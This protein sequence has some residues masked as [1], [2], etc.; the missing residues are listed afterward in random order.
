MKYLLSLAFFAFCTIGF[1]QN[2]DAIVGKWKT[3]DDETKEPKSIVELYKSSDGKL[4]GKVETILNPKKKNSVCDKCED[5]KKDQPVL[6]MIIVDGLEYDDGEWEDG[7]ILDPNNGTY[8]DC[9][10]WI[11]EENPDKLNV[12][13]YVAFF[14]RTQFWYRVQ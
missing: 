9:K 6:G 12:R 4:Y 14:Y 8:Y 1:S 5:D 13:G 7:T 2:N 10:M 11:D 3:I